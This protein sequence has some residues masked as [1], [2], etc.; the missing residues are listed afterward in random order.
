MLCSLGSPKL[1]ACPLLRRPGSKKVA[2][3]A[4][5]EEEDEEDPESLRIRVRHPKEAEQA[6]RAH[7][8]PAALVV[9]PWTP[10]AGTGLA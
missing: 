3:Q 5:T 9:T 4:S 1:P 7:R 2:P 6:L 8:A 10:L